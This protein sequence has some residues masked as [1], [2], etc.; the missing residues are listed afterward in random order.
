MIKYT[1]VRMRS[2]HANVKIKIVNYS[3]V[4]LS[5]KKMTYTM[6]VLKQGNLQGR[7]TEEI[8]IKPHGTS[9]IE[10]PVEISP[11][12]IVKTLF[13][14]MINKDSYDYTLKLNASLE[15]SGLLKDTFA[16]DIVKRGTMELKK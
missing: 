9:F 7:H 12:N 14:V 13:D 3:D 1:K 10:L 4:D 15:S 5:I 2:I 16:I 11:K 6:N 8:K